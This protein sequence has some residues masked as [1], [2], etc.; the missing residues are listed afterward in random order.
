M[1]VE[2]LMKRYNHDAEFSALVQSMYHAM[3]SLGLTPSELREAASFAA[4]MHESETV[5]RV[6]MLPS[7]HHGTGEHI[8]QQPQGA[9]LKP[10]PE[11]GGTDIR[12]PVPEK[13]DNYVWCKNT[14]CKLYDIEYSVRAWNT[15]H[16]RP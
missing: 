10:C 13:D 2:H 16:K 15:R 6:M 1:N 3:D 5:R 12:L 9:D 11:C 14:K 7:E 8:S 4:Y